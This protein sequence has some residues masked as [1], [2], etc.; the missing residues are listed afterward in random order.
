M[1][2]HTHTYK[3]TMNSQAVNRIQCRYHSTHAHLT[4]SPS[5]T[6]LVLRRGCGSMGHIL[7][8]CLLSN[9]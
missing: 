9:S 1:H 2:T 3:Q 7:S 4:P 5:L 6:L 8:S